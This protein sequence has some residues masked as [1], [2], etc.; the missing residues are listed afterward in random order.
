MMLLVLVLRVM[1]QALAWFP[2]VNL[3]PLVGVR[4]WGTIVVPRPLPLVESFGGARH[5]AGG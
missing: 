5:L 1:A 4:S 2:N 3:S